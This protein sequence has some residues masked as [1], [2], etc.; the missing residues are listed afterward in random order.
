[1]S[2]EHKVVYF[3]LSFINTYDM[4]VAFMLIINQSD[5]KKQQS[6]VTITVTINPMYDARNDKIAIL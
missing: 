4:C 5:L 2:I 3:I 1:M 6:C